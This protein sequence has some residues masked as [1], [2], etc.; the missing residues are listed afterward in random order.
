MEKVFMT[1]LSFIGVMVFCGSTLCVCTLC[2]S[3]I[4][5]LLE[6]ISKGVKL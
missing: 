4:E 1:V 2:R 3:V 6:D 5:G